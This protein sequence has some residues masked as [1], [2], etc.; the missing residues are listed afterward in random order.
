MIKLVRNT[1]QSKAIIFHRAKIIKWAYIENLNKYQNK[2]GMHLANKLRNAHVNFLKNKM[3]T[4]LAVQTLSLSVADAIEYLTEAGIPEFQGSEATVEFIRIFNNLFDIMNSKSKYGKEFKR[5]IS[6]ETAEEY[7]SFFQVA[8]TY[9]RELQILKKGVKTYILDSQNK[10]GFLGFL[11]AMQSFKNIFHNDVN[12]VNACMDYI[13]TFKYSQ[14]HLEQF[15]SK[16]RGRGG[17][18]DN[19]NVIQFKAALKRLLL[20]NDIISSVNSNASI[21]DDTQLHSVDQVSDSNKIW[22]DDSTGI[23]IDEE[24][25]LEELDPVTE[26]IV[27][28]ITGFVERQLF[29]RVK[30]SIC[31]E[32][33]VSDDTLSNALINKKMRGLLTIPQ[34]NLVY[35]CRIVEQFFKLYDNDIVEINLLKLNNDIFHTVIESNPNIFRDISNH[36]GNEGVDSHIYKLIK[37]TILSYLRIR[38][39]HQAKLITEDLYKTKF[40]NFSKKIVQFSG[41]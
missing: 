23:D 1:F 2:L 6:K 13:L 20:K 31:L 38:C 15:F 32:Y 12:S 9:I 40:R 21:L 22:M 30:C 4:K 18:N 10:T 8:D 16:I 24:Y 37:L 27:G 34:R 14:D 36:I 39:Y 5:P 25:L 19:P 17:L 11:I 26:D 41:Q 3:K 28:Y 7:F 33:L 29:K 35:I